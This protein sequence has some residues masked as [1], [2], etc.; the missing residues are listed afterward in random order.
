MSAPSVSGEEFGVN[1]ENPWLGLA[2]FTEELSSY[3]YGRDNET[4]ELFRLLK[5]ETLTV[6]FGQSG[7]GKTSM[8]QAGLFPQLRQADFLPVQIRL[9]YGEDAPALVTQVKAALVQRI[10]AGEVD[11]PK[12]DT[13]E[14]LWEYFHRKDVDFWNAKQHLT[15]PVLVFDQFEEIFT[16]GRTD[17]ARR[18][19]SQVFLTELAD[20]I[21]NRT[22]TVLKD[23]LDR[24][25]GEAIVFSSTR[26]AAR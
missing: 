14:T 23:K 25:D 9:L 15:T 7:L 21:E 17:H 8:L 10:E 12:P 4:A 1:R 13:S 6:L 5:R 3:F 11:A 22:P 26:R 24:G 18:S 19:Q 20:L 16:L 2:S